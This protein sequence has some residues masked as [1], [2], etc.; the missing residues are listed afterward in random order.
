MPASSQL[1]KKIPRESS[2]RNI[3][4]R[5][6]NHSWFQLLHCTL[7][8]FETQTV[9]TNNILD[10]PEKSKFSQSNR[11]R[12]DSKLYHAFALKHIQNQTQ[13]YVIELKELITDYFLCCVSRQWHCQ[14][15]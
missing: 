10:C 1:Q 14:I 15:L 5:N 4:P 2:S 11:Q 9:R 7:F 13:R 3:V 8:V 12:E 6:P